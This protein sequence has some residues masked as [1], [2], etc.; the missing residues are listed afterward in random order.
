M[1]SISS[2]QGLLCVCMHRKQNGCILF[3]VHLWKT[4]Q[5]I[6]SSW[7]NRHRHE[8]IYGKVIQR[9]RHRNRANAYADS[10]SRQSGIGLCR[11]QSN[12]RWI[13]SVSKAWFPGFQIWLYGYAS[14]M[15]LCRTIIKKQAW[16][17][18][19]LQKAGGPSENIPISHCADIDWSDFE[20]WHALVIIITDPAVMLMEQ[21]S[22]RIWSLPGLRIGHVFH[23]GSSQSR[24]L[25]CR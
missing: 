18:W 20:K 21:L 14:Y 6:I 16:H 1:D 5:S 12:R 15:Q 3:S 7:F 13:S 2:Q 8:C 25:A 22:L 17:S 23:N 24:I 11:T 9:K 10:K 4:C 19:N